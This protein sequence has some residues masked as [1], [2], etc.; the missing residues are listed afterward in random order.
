MK[1]FSF[2]AFRRRRETSPG[3]AAAAGPR[4]APRPQGE[5]F[6]SAA[7]LAIAALVPLLVLAAFGTYRNLQAQ[8]AEAET[9]SIDDARLLSAIVDRELAMTVDDADTLAASPTLDGPGPPDLPH[10]RALAARALEQHRLWLGVTLFG[11]NS[12]RLFR[13]P[14]APAPPPPPPLI[15]PNSFGRVI[16]THR[17]AIGDIMPEPAGWTVP[18]RVPV[19]RNGELRFVLTIHI[20]PD[21]LQ[22]L[23]G[24]LHAPQS[25]IITVINQD[26]HVVARSRQSRVLVGRHASAASTQARNRA[27]SGGGLYTGY[28]LEHV[29]TI[30]AFWKSSLTGWSVHIGIPRAELEGRLWRSALF[31][32]LGLAASLALSILF[33]L[34]FLRELEARRSRETALEQAVRLEALGRLTGGVAHDFN[35]VLTVIQGNVSI[36]RRKLKEPAAEPHLDAIRQAS[37]Q[38]AKRIRQLLVFARGG[39]PQTTT[40]DVNET[41]A[42]ALTAIRRL[43]APDITVRTSPSETPAWVDID[44]VQLEAALLNLAANARDAMPSGGELDIA[45]RVDRDQVYLSVTDTGEGVP[46]EVLSRVFE[47][48][49]TTK[50]G[51]KGT[52]LGLSQVYGLARSAGGSAEIRSTV[53]QGTTVALRLPL[54]RSSPEKADL[55]LGS[56]PVDVDGPRVLLVDD[57]KAVRATIASFLRNAGMTVREA[58]DTDEAL[59]LL[60][61]EPFDAVV[62][63]IVM[64]G[65]R[66]GLR[67]ACAARERRPDLRILLIS[68]FGPSAADAAAAGFPVLAKPIDLADLER[69]LRAPRGLSAPPA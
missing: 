65:A 22:A 36:L 16:G 23:I 44:P 35:N 12:R 28:N 42:T 3:A 69:R 38:A 34:L 27:P 26:D 31:M 64:P 52:G 49:F 2:S 4:L 43:V 67:L 10:F 48:F 19:I 55:N 61:A 5:A 62:T 24:E 21:R 33:L 59:A 18:V 41:I 14:Q 20:R 46:P 11:A 40:V 45:V 57:D 63:D 7:L 8:R 29:Q 66:D 47:P 53:G 15:D 68:G 32:I 30:S 56:A 51:D 25:W 54:A 50:A 58:G 1:R 37:D 13:V 17:P 60:E 6:R 9:K 39:V